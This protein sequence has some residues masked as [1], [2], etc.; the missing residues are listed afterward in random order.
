MC[1]CTGL[2]GC[3]V[4]T[5]PRTAIVYE[6]GRGEPR[7]T[8]TEYLGEYALYA[9]PPGADAPAGGAASVAS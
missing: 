1:A 4:S 5:G 9:V 8:R 3:H 2:S 6:P 7:E